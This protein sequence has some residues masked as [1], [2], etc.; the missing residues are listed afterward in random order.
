MRPQGLI[1]NTYSLGKIKNKVSFATFKHSSASYRQ[2]RTHHSLHAVQY[3]TA[4]LDFHRLL[5]H[6]YDRDIALNLT[7]VFRPGSPEEQQG[8][9]R[10]GNFLVQRDGEQSYHVPEEATQVEPLPDALQQI[11][12]AF[13]PTSTVAGNL[14]PTTEPT[15]SKG[16][17]A[18]PNRTDLADA[19]ANESGG[20]GLSTGAIVGIA[21]GA[22]IAGLLLIAALVWFFCRRRRSHRTKNSGPASPYGSDAAQAQHAANKESTVNMTETPQSPYSENGTF[23]PQQFQS[24]SQSRQSNHT[25]EGT[26]LVDHVGAPS[27]AGGPPNVA[28]PFSDA[29][30]PTQSQPHSEPRPG[31]RSVTPNVAH[32]IEEGMT[33]EEIRRLEE[34]ERALDDAIQAAQ[35]RRAS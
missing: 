7:W 19:P 30:P 14:S 13:N 35:S 4:S 6:H 21:V 32:L 2:A 3:S 27:V 26:P 33:E 9:S 12:D 8:W 10:S 31:A 18:P 24:H 34:E 5:D 25:R 16:P 20:A 29:D 22:G 11:I 15:P 17:I 28:V 1:R 23:P